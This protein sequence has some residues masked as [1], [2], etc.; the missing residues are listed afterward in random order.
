MEGKRKVKLEFRSCAPVLKILVI[1]LILLC[2]VALV[3]LGWYGGGIREQIRELKAAAA[4][5]EQDNR[6]LEEKID[7]LGS[8]QSDR[9]IAREELGLVDPAT[10][11]IQPE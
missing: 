8:V 1:V 9:E 5:P 2:S 11:V 3:A 6:E 7:N 10:I 4:A